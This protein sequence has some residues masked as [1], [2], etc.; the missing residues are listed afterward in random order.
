[1]RAAFALWF[2]SWLPLMYLGV[3]PTMYGG[4]LR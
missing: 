1:M 4:C 3:L 2:Q